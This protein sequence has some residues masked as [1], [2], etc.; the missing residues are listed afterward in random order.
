[1]ET[2]RILRKGF[3]L[4]VAL[5][6]CTA[7]VLAADMPIMMKNY[8]ANGDGKLVPDELPDRIRNKVMGFADRDLSGDLT[9]NEVPDMLW[10]KVLGRFDAN[11]NGKLD[12]EELVKP[13]KK[14]AVEATMARFADKVTL[15]SDIEYATGSEYADDRGKLDVYVPK[16]KKD[17]PVLFFIHGGG[18]SNG[19]KQSLAA[20]AMRFASDGFGVVAMNYR[21]STNDPTVLKAQYPDHIEDIAK[22]FRWT[23]DNIGKHGGNRKRII[24][25]GGSAGG[26]LA[27]LLAL[28][29]RFLKAEGLSTDNIAGCIDISG[30][31]DARTVGEV[32]IK[33]Q[34]HGDPKIV[35]KASPM[36]YVRKDAPP[37][38]IL[39]AENESPERIDQNKLLFEKLKKCGHP[40]VAFSILKDRT[41][42]TI[43]SNMT[44]E[45]DQAYGLMRDFTRKHGS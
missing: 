29:G 36:T 43:L 24:V 30:L 17:F 23:Y 11:A 35:K 27:A 18:L 38:L 26:H 15:M 42:N 7:S 16:G 9:P 21:L 45:G 28:D 40:D 37:M 39:V 1:M 13:D 33:T 41:H 31:V 25:S 14:G 19:S 2:K 12:G 20:A 44:N 10:Q 3:A 32:R 4:V 5:F 6:L 34:F 8:D 22:A